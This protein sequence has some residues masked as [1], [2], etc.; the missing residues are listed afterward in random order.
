MW[1]FS[2]HLILLRENE[3]ESLIYYMSSVQ[4]LS[5]Q[6]AQ[7]DCI[8]DIWCYTQMKICTVN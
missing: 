3:K 8:T 5:S 4:E 7:A 2:N 1:W 6:W